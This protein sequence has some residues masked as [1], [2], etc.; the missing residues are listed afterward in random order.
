MCL[1][2]VFSDMITLD[3][4]VPVSIC[5][6]LIGCGMNMFDLTSLVRRNHSSPLLKHPQVSYMSL[7]EWILMH[8]VGN[9]FDVPVYDSSH[10]TKW[11]KL[12]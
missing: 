3:I 4:S 1:H 8:R 5:F 11:V 9:M 7:L 2:A 6:I 10:R 12:Y